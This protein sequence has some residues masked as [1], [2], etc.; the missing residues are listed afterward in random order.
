VD[1]HVAAPV[2]SQPS[3]PFAIGRSRSA[4]LNLSD[5]D[6]AAVRDRVAGGCEVLGLRFD[7]DRFVG[8]RFDA[9]HRELG[10]GFIAIEYP[11]ANRTDH[12]VLTEQRVDDGVRQ[13]LAFFDR[14]LRG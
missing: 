9:L 8:T 12:S 5:E 7:Q 4:D 1:G 2:L 10:E 11:S 3:L 13:V 6:L 14:K